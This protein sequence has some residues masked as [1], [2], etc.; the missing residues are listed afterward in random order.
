[1][2]SGESDVRISCYHCKKTVVDY[3]KCYKCEYFFH[4][5]CMAQAAQKK[6][7]I[8]RHELIGMQVNN[9]LTSNLKSNEVLLAENILLRQLIDEMRSKQEVL[10]ENCLLLRD[11]VIFLEKRVSD[12]QEENKNINQATTKNSITNE[13]TGCSLAGHSSSYASKIVDP[14][15]V[16]ATANQMSTRGTSGIQVVKDHTEKAR[17]VITSRE[18]NAAIQKAQTLSKMA[19]IQNLNA[20]P[21]DEGWQLQ[22]HRRNKRFVVGD[23][24]EC[25]KELRAVPKYVSLHV[26][27]M[28]PETK[29]EVMKT[30]LEKEFPEVVCE[31][32][33]S[34][35]PELY[36]SFKI[37]IKQEN[38]KKAWR[39]DLWPQGS[40]VSRFFFKKG[41]PSQ[42]Q[43]RVD[44]P[45]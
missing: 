28:D 36:S 39:R 29:P 15:P 44:P 43:V 26:T 21:E 2:S 8:C 19:E 40:L 33:N 38:F 3:V 16:G 9:N 27:R 4:P 37:T 6:T 25:S 31:K 30:I 12:L 11:K 34:K 18:V 35:Y 32:I 24:S 14:H 23:N 17:Q 45:Q 20:V 41:M 13:L 5:A 10:S 7:A 42:T 22:K 1:M